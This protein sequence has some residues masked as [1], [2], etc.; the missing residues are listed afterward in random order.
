VS[1]ILLYTDCISTNVRVYLQCTN[2]VR[3]W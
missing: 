2:W 1:T 3:C